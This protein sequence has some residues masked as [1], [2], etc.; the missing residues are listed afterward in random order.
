MI[1]FIIFM[2]NARLNDTRSDEEQTD[3]YELW[4][5]EDHNNIHIWL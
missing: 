1:A 2:C 5:K 4:I 3:K